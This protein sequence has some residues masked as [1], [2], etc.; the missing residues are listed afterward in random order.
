MTLRQL[1][2]MVTARQRDEWERMAVLVAKIHNRT[3][4][5]TKEDPLEVLDVIPRRLITD[6]DR[7]A[8]RAAKFA[9]VL[10]IP[11]K[12]GAVLQAMVIGGTD[13]RR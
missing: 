1:A 8:A 2:W 9:N 4:F 6:A 5:D 10:K 13:G 7:A 3:R 12:A 11:G